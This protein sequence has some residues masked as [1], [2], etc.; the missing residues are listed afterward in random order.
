MSNAE[1]STVKAIRYFFLNLFTP[2]N[3][4]NSC[5]NNIRIVAIT[6][7]SPNLIIP[8]SVLKSKKKMNRQKPIHD[9]ING[10]GELYR[11]ARN[12]HSSLFWV[13]QK[14]SPPL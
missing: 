14:S 12:Q 9:M 7:Y 6:I 5:L 4:N 13:A 8:Y 2:L 3:R 1:N 11:N 10:D